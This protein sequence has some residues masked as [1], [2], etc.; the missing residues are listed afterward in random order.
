M[1][2]FIIAVTYQRTIPKHQF[3]DMNLCRIDNVDTEDQAIEKC[4]E[5]QYHI[6]MLKE[7]Y[8]VLVYNAIKVKDK[9]TV[10]DMLRE[11]PEEEVRKIIGQWDYDLADKKILFDDELFKHQHKN[12]YP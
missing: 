8:I 12:Q 10:A 11:L 9:P 5:R 3:T 1:N 7:G 6:E 2:S 4:F